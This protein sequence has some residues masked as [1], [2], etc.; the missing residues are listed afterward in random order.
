MVMSG[1][2]R[3]L[4]HNVRQ[5]RRRIHQTVDAGRFLPKVE[6]LDERV[7][8]TVTASFTAAAGELRVVG[9][10]LDNTIVVSRNAAGTILVNNG[11]VAIQGDPGAT[12]ANT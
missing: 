10:A 6:R 12:V 9:D 4:V 2:N 11:A 5:V 8:P 1:L 7:M 3:C